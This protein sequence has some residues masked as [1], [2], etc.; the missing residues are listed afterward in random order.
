MIS[1]YMIV[2]FCA[3]L[4]SV[5]FSAC[6]TTLRALSQD[7][8]EVQLI[9]KLPLYYGRQ[10]RLFVVKHTSQ[11]F[12]SASSYLLYSWRNKNISYALRYLNN[13]NYLLPVVHPTI[14]FDLNYSVHLTWKFDF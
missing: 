8:H 1:S 13:S 2:Q 10:F 12:W 5:D 6:T 7:A 11:Q 4:L 3:S 14:Y 9:D